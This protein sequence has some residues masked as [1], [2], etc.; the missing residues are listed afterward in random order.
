[1]RLSHVELLSEL[2]GTLT[3][4]LSFEESNFV[5]LSGYFDESEDS[6]WFTLG[7]I[8]STGMNWT[9]LRT[10]WMNCLEKK[11][12]QLTDEGRPTISRFHA[13]DCWQGSKEFQGWEPLEREAFRSELKAIIDASDGFHIVSHSVKVS[14]LAEVFNIKTH[15]KMKRAC[16]RLL[17][18]YLMM[19][20]GNDVESRGRGY[21][22]VRIS[23]IHDRTTGMDNTILDAFNQLKNDETFQ[24]RH[25]FITI[26]PMGWE[27]CIPLQPAD[28][29]AYESRKQVYRHKNGDGLGGELK[30]LLDLPSFGGSGHFFR[31]DN[32]EELKK[33]LGRLWLGEESLSN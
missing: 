21:E 3:G 7:C 29:I 28:M 17:V 31:R 2:W 30:E 14:E 27:N 6:E 19:Q 20:I 5:V 16:Y 33:L 18:Q 10:D 9:W 1:M 23:L 4:H 22:H 11:N 13:S 8:F 15:K 12:K 24:S 25:R 32:L 26:A